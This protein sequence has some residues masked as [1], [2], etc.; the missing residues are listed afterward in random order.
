MET[1]YLFNRSPAS[2]AIAQVEQVHFGPRLAI[3]YIL[4]RRCLHIQDVT[5]SLDFDRIK[6]G[7]HEGPA[8]VP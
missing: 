7:I 3:V 8:R 1:R 6:L 4:N 5:P 2:Q